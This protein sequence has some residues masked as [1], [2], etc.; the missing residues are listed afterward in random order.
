MDLIEVKDH[1][2]FYMIP[3]ME[4]FALSKRGKLLNTNTGRLRKWVHNKRNGYMETAGNIN[5]KP[6]SL[7]RARLMCLM[8]KP[9]ENSENFQV[10]HISG[11]KTDDRLENLEWC[12]PLENTL[13]AGS[14]GLSPKCKPVFVTDPKTGETTRY[15][16][17]IDYA[18]H[19]GKSR[20]KIQYHLRFHY[21]LPMDDGTK[22]RYENPKFDRM[23]KRAMGNNLSIHVR[24]IKTGKERVYDTVV[25]FATSIGLAP[26][27]ITDALKRLHQP[28]VRG[29]WQIQLLKNKM[30]WRELDDISV[31]IART[32]GAKPIEV[33]NQKTNEHK[34]YETVEEC[35]EDNNISVNCLIWRLKSPNKVCRDGLIY[36][37][38]DT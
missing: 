35:A 4:P 38:L 30:P 10:N 13:H 12:T 36:K 23:L 29:R 3:G 1:P 25:K 8:F 34:R 33:I 20:D 18:R 22:I 24:D 19:S 21:G 32:N 14:T 16:S 27:V 2:G 9:I 15:L 26:S 7:R 11:F 5:G 6:R 31:E 28:V 37:Y 17:C